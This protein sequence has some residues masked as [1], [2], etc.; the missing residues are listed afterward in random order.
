MVAHLTGTPWLRELRR[1]LIARTVLVCFPPGGGAVTAYRSLAGL[2][3]P[4]TTVFAVQYPGRQDRYAD[5]PVGVLTDLAAAIADDLL[6]WPAGTRPALFGHSMGATVAYETARR[7]ADAGRAPAHLFVSGRPMPAYLESG[8]VHLGT[9]ADLIVELERL[10]NDP[11][12]VAILREEP[13]LAELVLPAV[14]ADYTAVETYRHRPGDPLPCPITALVSTEDPTVTVEQAGEWASYTTA[15]FD[16]VT[17]PGAH[18]YLDLP[19]QT[20][21]VAKALTDR[22]AAAHSS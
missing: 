4:G 22:L 20:P 12:S 1:D 21:A 7:L 9:D 17:F 3:G 8:R 10:A 19:D 14:R 5:E 18:F 15:D 16:L 13:G 2:I 6:S 11:A